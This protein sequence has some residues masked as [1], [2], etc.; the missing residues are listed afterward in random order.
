M[1]TA[2]YRKD[3]GTA[4]ASLK[5]IVAG[6]V[7]DFQMTYRAGKYGIDDSG[8]LMLVA[9][10]PSDYAPPQFADPRGM[11][12]M[13][14]SCSNPNVKFVTRWGPKIHLRPWGKGVEIKVTGG[15]LMPGDEIYVDF[16]RW[17]AQTFYEKTFEFKVLVDPIA[18]GEYVPIMRSPEIAIV[19]GKPAKLVLVAPSQ[20]RVGERF[21]LG[22]KVEDRWGN[23]CREYSGTVRLASRRELAGLSKSVKLIKGR[24]RVNGLRAAKEGLIELS[25]RCGKLRAGS[26]PVKVVAEARLGRYWA[27]LHAQSEETVGTSSIEE[28]FQFAR[29]YA[30]LDAISHQGNDFQIT[31]DFWRRVQRNTKH[32]YRPGSFV[33]FPGYEYSAN[34]GLG[35]DRNVLHMTEGGPLHRSSHALVDDYSDIKTDA[36]TATELFR[37]LKGRKSLV[38]AHVGGRYANMDMHDDAVERAVELHSAWGTFEWLLRDSLKRGHRVGVVCNSDGHK[39]RPGASYP[40]SGKFGSYGGLTC[41]L[42]EKLARREVFDAIFA[43]HTY[44]TTGARMGLDVAL[45]DAA[46]RECGIMGDVLRAKKNEVYSLRIVALGTSPVERVEVFQGLERIALRVPRLAPGAPRAVKII[47]AG[48]EFRGR[49][50]LVFWDGTLQAIGAKIRKFEEINFLDVEKGLKR[51]SA[52]EL[53]WAG[54]TTGGLQGVILHLDKLRGVIDFNTKRKRV[55]IPVAKLTE[56]PKVWNA[57]GLDAR[58]EAHLTSAGKAPLELAFDLPIKKLKKGD[59]PLYV[60]VTQ[61]DGHMAW[62]SPI[63]VRA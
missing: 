36:P 60:K 52:N 22:L 53:I 5:R 63:Y 10:F 50:R 1:S 55:N 16:K 12:Y 32:Y 54:V 15:F 8:G 62:S 9:R 30:F 38:F 26:N 20:V 17:R 6:S 35:G 27:D 43:R 45:L 40:G 46:G 4:R 39:C 51:T 25:G 57:G 56:R 29:D 11:N 34:T 13:R 33:T 28:Y 59:N 21:R 42:A 18:T 3:L 58:V 24:A 14:V 31:K 48:S 19:A 41:I 61:R 49:A 2:Y 7:V 37:R 44:G 23:P 47:T